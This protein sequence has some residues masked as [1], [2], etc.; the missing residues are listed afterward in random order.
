MARLALKILLPVLLL[1]LGV[2]VA[3][4]MVKTKPKAKRAKPAE[5]A[6]VVDVAMPQADAGRAVVEAQGTVT[7]DRVVQLTPQVSGIVEKVGE[8]VVP[9]ARLRAGQLIAVVDDRDLRIVLDQRQ[10]DLVRARFE[11]DVEKGRG[12]VADRE[13]AMLGGA[14]KSSKLGAALAQRKPHI[15]AAKA[16]VEAAKS[17][18]EK[19]RLDISR[20]RVVAPFDCVVRERR[21][22][23]GQLV[24]PQ[25]PLVV[26]VATDRFF[27]T[28]N[29]PVEKLAAIDVPGLRGVEDG[30]GASAR[31]RQR[32]AEGGLQRQG[33][34]LRLLSDLDPAARLARVLVEVRAPLEPPQ[35]QPDALPLLL[36]SYVSVAID[37]RPV[38]GVRLPRLALREGERVFTVEDGRLAFRPVEVVWRGSEDVVVRGVPAGVPVILSR[39]AAPEPG[40]KMTIRGQEEPG[41]KAEKADTP[42]AKAAAPAAAKAPR[43]EAAE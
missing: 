14:V 42:S 11:L 41:P 37:G 10:A 2:G 35:D 39:L 27:V 31:I 20:T 24:S 5:A 19:A 26:L 3:V 25:A 17:A 23:E 15:E 16:R 36:G 6:L 12:E 43:P 4:R 28:A 13:W 34:V 7:A 33:R 38:D 32:T 40:M 29:V 1:G 8:E 30:K 9:G 21:V 22:A 18:V